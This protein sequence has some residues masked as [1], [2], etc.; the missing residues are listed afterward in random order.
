MTKSDS[1]IL[2][3]LLRDQ[4]VAH[5]PDEFQIRVA[6]VFCQHGECVGC[7]VVRIVDDV[8]I[9]KSQHPLVV[10]TRAD[11]VQ[12]SLG[13][14]RIILTDLVC[15][16]QRVQ[17]ESRYGFAALHQAVCLAVPSTVLRLHAP[18]VLAT[19]MKGTLLL[20]TGY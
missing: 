20:I 7:R 15:V 17:N 5:P 9:R 10:H 1:T 16:Q 14:I 2:V 13:G 3:E 6:T 12:S 18:K 11:E 8:R 4:V 19:A